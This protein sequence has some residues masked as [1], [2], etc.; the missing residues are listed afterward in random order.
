MDYYG[1]FPSQSPT[2]PESVDLK[3]SVRLS[4]CVF[5]TILVIRDLAINTGP[6]IPCDERKRRLT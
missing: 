3:I 2:C 5:T 6:V 1:C 4:F